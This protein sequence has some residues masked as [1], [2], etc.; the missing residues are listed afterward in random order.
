VIFVGL[1]RRIEGYRPDVPKNVPLMRSDG[2]SFVGDA[3]H[4]I[5][6]QDYPPRSVHNV[7]IRNK[8][9]G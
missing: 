7:S 9:P 3:F 4:F 1:V 2:H 8:L 5:A 6:G